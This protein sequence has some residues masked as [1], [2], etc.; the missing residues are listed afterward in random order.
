MPRTNGGIIGKRNVTSFGKCTVTSKTSS[1]CLTTQPGTRVAQ[2]LIVAGGGSGAAVT[3]SHNAAGGG[4]AGG[5]RCL[6]IN[7]LCGNTT[8]PI[9][10]GGGGASRS[11]PTDADGN[12]A[13]SYTHL[14]AHET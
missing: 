13:V 2:T 6:E 10:V 1:G 8:Y 11:G 7:T 3:P 14:R 4:G 12:S 5:Y 9:V